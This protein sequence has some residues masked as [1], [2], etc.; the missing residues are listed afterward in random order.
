MGQGD[1]FS[2]RVPYAPTSTI[3]ERGRRAGREPVAPKGDRRRQARGKRAGG[4]GTE[5]S[6]PAGRSEERA[7][8]WAETGGGDGTRAVWGW[9]L[10]FVKCH[11]RAASLAGRSLVPSRQCDGGDSLRKTD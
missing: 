11:E 7:S 1:W 6:Q 9:G 3:R 2:V 5:A 8:T 10:N 4:A